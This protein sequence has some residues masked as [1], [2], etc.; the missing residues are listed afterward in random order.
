[1]ISFEDPTVLDDFLNSHFDQPMEYKVDKTG[2]L[3]YQ[4]HNEF[5]PLRKLKKKKKYQ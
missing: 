2:R 4:C 3:V 5:G 1:M